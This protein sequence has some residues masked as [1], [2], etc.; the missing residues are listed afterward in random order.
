MYAATFDKMDN[1]NLNIARKN[2]EDKKRTNKNVTI[3]L[4]K[5]K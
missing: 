3:D 5:I 2:S 1:N 4:I